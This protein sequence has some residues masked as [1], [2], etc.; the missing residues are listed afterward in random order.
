VDAQNG[1]VVGENGFFARTNNGGEFWIYSS[2]PA[3]LGLLSVFFTG[4]KTGYAVGGE[5]PQGGF[6]LRTKDEG[7]NWT[8]QDH[9]TPDA[10]TSIV[11]TDANAGFAASA[12]T[13]LSTNN[14]GDTWNPANIPDSNFYM[15][16]AVHFP[17]SNVGYAVSTLGPLL[18]TING[19]K[20]WVAGELNPNYSSSLFFTDS[21]TGFVT[22]PGIYKTT[23]AGQTWQLTNIIGVTGSHYFNSIFFP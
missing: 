6:I 22:A 13:F 21:S 23:D 9:A 2:T 20:T 5:S 11:F 18:K 14:G 8:M 17:N 16:K 4:I 7:E 1:Y 19:G 12:R 10:L 3:S 15:L